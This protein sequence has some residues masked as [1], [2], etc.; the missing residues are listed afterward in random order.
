MYFKETFLFLL[1]SATLQGRLVTLRIMNLVSA[2]Q[3]N[4]DPV[5]GKTLTTLEYKFPHLKEI[6]QTV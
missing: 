1:A 6:N 2:G 5:S 3:L 4:A